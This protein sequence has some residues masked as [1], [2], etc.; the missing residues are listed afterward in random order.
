[1]L[2]DLERLSTTKRAEILAVVALMVTAELERQQE[3][4]SVSLEFELQ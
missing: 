1:M 4:Y 3:A 2:E